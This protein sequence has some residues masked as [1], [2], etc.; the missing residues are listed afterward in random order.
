M[1]SSELRKKNPKKGVTINPV[2][3]LTLKDRNMGERNVRRGDERR[4]DGDA[5]RRTL[6]ARHAGFIHAQVLALV[7]DAV[8]RAHRHGVPSPPSGGHS[9]PRK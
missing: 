7:V 8:A 9:A 3:V 5:E 2:L 1:A 4:G 6:H